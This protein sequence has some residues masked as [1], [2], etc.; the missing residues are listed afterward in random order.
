MPVHRLL[1]LTWFCALLVEAPALAAP[2]FVPSPRQA[3]EGFVAINAPRPDVPVG[4]LWID[5]YGPTGEA[6]SADNLETVR[7]LQGMSI[8]KGFQ[9][10][11]SLGLLQLFGV[12]PR[13]RD[14][15]TARLTDLSIVRVKDPAR[16]SGPKGE[17][18]IVEAIKAASIIV[19][20]DLEFG[21]NGQTLGWRPRGVEGTGTS[22]RTKASAI[23]ARDMFIAIRVAT[24]TL[25]HGK[26]RELDL[27]RIGGSDLAAS[28]D[29]YRIIV[30]NGACE[31][32]GKSS[33]SAP[34]LGIVKLSSHPAEP[35]AQL[36]SISQDGSV[37]LP[38]PVPTAD[39]KGG[40]FDSLQLRW[41]ASCKTTKSDGCGRRSKL[42]AQYLGTRLENVK[43][44]SAPGW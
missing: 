5:G 12:D 43:D 35:P 38:L 13:Y 32:G 15:F 29:D 17:P 4:A 25:T 33:C 11:L 21:L 19:S 7:S 36:A 27:E 24:P 8:D 6:A 39:G 42:V 44:A 18:R 22:G 31:R 2:T 3:F 37:Q 14:R 40:L 16:L 20:S 9:F 28:L 23:E 10:T 34:E 41:I 26:E 1:A 30:R